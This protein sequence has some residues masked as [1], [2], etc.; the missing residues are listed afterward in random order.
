ML[1]CLVSNA[2]WE[3]MGS[4]LTGSAGNIT[5]IFCIDVVDE[6]IVW[7]VPISQP[8]QSMRDVIRTLDA[9][10]SWSVTQL[11]ETTGDF[12][13][14]RIVALNEMEAWVS[15]L[16]VPAQNT[17]RI[18][19][20]IDGGVNWVELPGPFNEVGEGVQNL[21][22]FNDQDGVAFGS[23][24]GGIIKVYHT[25]DGGNAWSTVL[26]ANLPIPLFQERYAMFD[27]N[28]SYAE[29]GDTLWFTTTEN[30]VY[31]TV[32]KGLSW[33]AYNTPLPGSSSVAGIASIAFQDHE[34]G[35][36]VSYQPQQG[37]ITTDG[38]LTWDLIEMPDAPTAASVQYVPGTD[39]LF[40]L[41]DGFSGA[42]QTIAYTLN[43]GSSWGQLGGNPSLNTLEFLSPTVGWA[44]G[45]IGL[46]GAGMYKWADDWLLNLN[47]GDV[48][49]VYLKIFPNPAQESLFIELPTDIVGRSE[50]R[51]YDATGKPV[52]TTRSNTQTIATLNINSLPKGMYIIQI[53]G[54]GWQSVQKFIKG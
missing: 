46:D 33:Q 34:N 23:P 50:M 45:N 25:S 53:F 22:F 3:S 47:T 16:G 8:P 15:V 4:G 27:G 21:H 39:G 19:H 32:N 29:S 40:L 52:L 2:Q 31:R 28:G 51:V 12:M 54:D 30:R 14:R 35:M 9:G 41:S 6:D 24:A 20:T 1:L 7:A 36:A 44:G 48:A 37:A 38:G 43:N 49:E 17:S 42:S 18:Y 10:D 26:S 13:P 11:P 5:G